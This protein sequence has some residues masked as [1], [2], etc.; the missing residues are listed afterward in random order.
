[1]KRYLL[2]TVSTVALL[3]GV[4]T[5][6]VAQDKS[7][8]AAQDPS[9]S[10]PDAGAIPKEGTTQDNPAMQQ[11]RKMTEE[12]AGSASSMDS[13]SYRSYSENK[14]TIAGALISGNLSAD[15]L[16]GAKVSNASGDTIGEI[17]DLMVDSK[18]EVRKAIVEV[19]GFLGIGSKNVA[20]DLAEL[21][22]SAD[23]GFVSTMTKEELTTLPEYKKENGSWVR[24]ET[25]SDTKAK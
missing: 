18:N 11:D 2:T 17:G 16:L 19:G 14:D 20:V 4:A 15:Q 13:S 12:H 1:M 23:K 10:A 6:A 21:K 3:F 5:M 24:N 25:Q 22:Q 9:V 8:P 7:A